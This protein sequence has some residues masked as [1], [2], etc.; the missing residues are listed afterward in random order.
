MI[1]T[2]ETRCDS[3]HSHLSV[4]CIACGTNQYKSS[5]TACS[6]CGTNAVAAAGAG[7]CSCPNGYIPVSSNINVD[8]CKGV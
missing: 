6:A 3:I 8:G 4:A 5:S 1:R 7:T 2:T